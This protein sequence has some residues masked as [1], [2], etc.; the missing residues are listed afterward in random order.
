MA[1]GY[2]IKAFEVGKDDELLQQGVVA[3]VALGIGMGVATFLRGLTE[4]GNIK[5]V[6]FVDIHQRGLR[7][8]YGRRNEREAVLKSTQQ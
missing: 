2:G 6:G 3:D 8:C 7:L 5:Q 4:E 1:D